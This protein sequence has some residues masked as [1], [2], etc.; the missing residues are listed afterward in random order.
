MRVVG[1]WMVVVMVAAGV[2]CARKPAAVIPDGLVAR[3]GGRAIVQADL[4]RQLQRM[5]AGLRAQYAVPAQRRAL[6]ET[7]INTELLVLEAER[8]GYD[9]DPEFRQRVKHQLINNLLEDAFDPRADHEAR[10]RLTQ[11]LL[12]ESR[13]RFGVQIIDPALQEPPAVTTG[14]GPRD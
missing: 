14:P 5:P 3:V 11:K 12:L 4:D 2:S 9:Q 1:G 10:G 7:V 6:L 13:G 8:R